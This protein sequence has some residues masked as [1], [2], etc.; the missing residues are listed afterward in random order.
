MRRVPLVLNT[1]T[2]AL[3]EKACTLPEQ[4]SWG[5]L[6]LKAQHVQD[7]ETKLGTTGLRA[8][9]SKPIGHTL[10]PLLPLTQAALRPQNQI[11]IRFTAG[12]S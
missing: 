6:N 12:S 4:N 2:L 9:T 8:M 11:L 7:E 1:A 5:S 3:T 10:Q